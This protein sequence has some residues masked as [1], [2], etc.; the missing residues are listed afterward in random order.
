MGIG[1]IIN[2]LEK[3]SSIYLTRDVPPGSRQKVVDAVAKAA[4]N[5][6]R[7]YEGC[8]RCVLQALNEHLGL[9]TP[10]GRDDC[11]K[12]STALAAGV[13]RM[14]ETCG[15]LTGAVMAIGLEY[16]SGRLDQFDRY[17]ETM[18]KARIL[19]RQFKELYGSVK[20]TDIQE[21]VLGRRYDFDKEE[22]R[23]AWYKDGGLDKCPGVCAA[24]ARIAAEIILEDREKR[25]GKI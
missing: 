1:D 23:E 20:C 16:G 4:Y 10:E 25:N 17:V 19:F 12:A 13:A 6:N 18:N 24:A 9:T 3:D 8:T 7:T 2:K 5:N 11:I 21:K 14:G 15:A 22:D